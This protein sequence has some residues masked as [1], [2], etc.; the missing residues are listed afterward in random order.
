MDLD[1]SFDQPPRW[2][3]SHR[4]DP[5]SPPSPKQRTQQ[6]S[7]RSNGNRNGDN[8]SP[9][10]FE[11]D[12]YDALPQDMDESM[13]APDDSPSAGRA[14]ARSSRV[15]DP[16]PASR[17]SSSPAE[18][19]NAS[20]NGSKRSRHETEEDTAVEHFP[21]DDAAIDDDGPDLEPDV[22]RPPP[23]K[24]Q[25]KSPP[26][27][28]NGTKSNVKRPVTI[29]EEDEAPNSK[30]NNH[31]IVRQRLHEHTTSAQGLRSTRHTVANLF[32]R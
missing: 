13:A 8:D 7:F 32:H 9:D 19:P 5:V 25:R 14:A 24:K 6:F 18:P 28:P 17:L 31:R 27:K 22:S 1:D 12:A 3:P 16:S 29:G 26:P 30:S 15:R 11:T 4:H 2:Q 10:R 21:D 23:K 20:K